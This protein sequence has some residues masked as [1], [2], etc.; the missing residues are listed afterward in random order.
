[1]LERESQLAALHQ[2]LEAADA[3]HGHLVLV[4]GEAGA[5]KSTVLASFRTAI[6][7]SVVYA[8]GLCDPLT[9]PRALGPLLDVA[10]DLDLPAGQAHDVARALLRKAA[11]RTT[12]VVIED[13]HWAD[14]ATLDAVV[15]LAR[16]LAEHHLLLIVSYRD[17]EVPAGHPLRV[18]LGR[19]ATSRPHRVDIPLLSR[20]AVHRLAAGSTLDPDELVRVTGGNPFF[21]TEVL[22]AGEERLPETIV[23]SV[24]A[25]AASLSEGGRLALETASVMPRGTTDAL[26]THLTSS[27]RGIDEARAAGLLDDVRGRLRFRHEIARLAVESSLDSRRRRLLHQTLLTAL[28]DL[29]TAA[30]YGLDVADLAHHAVEAGAA[31]LIRHYCWAAAEEAAAVGAHRAA[32]ANWDR[33]LAAGGLT[34]EDEA[35]ALEGRGTALGVIGRAEDACD[36]YVAAAAV[37]SQLGERGRQGE[38]LA[39]VAAH[40]WLGGHGPRAREQVDAA[41]TMLEP[42]GGRSLAVALA[43]QSRLRMLAR[44]TAG[45]VSAGERAVELATPFGADTVL[46]RAYN[47]IGTALWFSDPE[48]AEAPL[49]QALELARSAAQ[50]NLA[51][52]AMVNLG[53]GA[54]EIRRY[55]VAELWLDAAVTW[56]ADHDLDGNGDYA[57]AW[58]ARVALERGRWA[59]AAADAH[60]VASRSGVVNARIVALTTLGLLRSR[61]GD[62]DAGPV[63]AEAW[64]LA[65]ETGDLQRLWPAAAARAEAEWWSDGSINDIAGLRT[66]FELA[67]SLRHGWAVGDLVGWLRRAGEVIPA[68]LEAAE[69]YAAALAGDPALAARCWDRLGCPFEAAVALLDADQESMILDAMH[70]FDALDA[71]AA[72]RAARV[73]L[74]DLGVTHIPRG[75]RVSTKEDPYGLTVREQ[76]VM[77]GLSRGLTNAAIAAELVI[78]PR[79]VDRHVS[80]VLRKLNASTR[81][82]AVSVLSR[83]SRTPR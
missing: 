4:T 60:H 5:G 83:V 68:G 8:V 19:V 46:S 28:P 63:L 25:R 61:R 7:T 49:L 11:D 31:D 42:V 45:A 10:E 81:A 9:T 53:S 50:D 1:M 56:C 26:L 43:E 41:V 75:P 79:T 55:D 21:V 35:T 57:R 65:V 74:R 71:S 22:A 34:P 17:D 58:R 36:A 12:V 2:S 48:R 73:R 69:P 39:C 72:S 6:A 32:A 13:A 18:A 23:D 77:G 38:A 44:D 51:A 62:P 14:D 20:D 70:R 27:A 64:D 47:S 76:E 80:N 30:A 15:F 37:W 67:V 33:V 29:R 59:A 82:E 40:L 16:R 66:T 54:G 78:S 52:S 24:I 3:G